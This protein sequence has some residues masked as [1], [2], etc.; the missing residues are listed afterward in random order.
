MKLLS[1]LVVG[2]LGLTEDERAA[3]K[4][5]DQTYYQYEK[6]DTEGGTALNRK[7]SASNNWDGCHYNHQLPCYKKEL[8]C[9]VSTALA[10]QNGSTPRIQLTS[11]G[12]PDHSAWALT[13]QTSGNVPWLL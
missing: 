3:F 6:V 13:G 8:K 10:T 7:A 1:A 11:N 2:A 5:R 12:I 9:E 4:C